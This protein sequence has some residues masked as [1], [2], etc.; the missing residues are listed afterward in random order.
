[1]KLPLAPLFLLA[2]TALSAQATPAWTFWI[3][4]NGVIQRGPAIRLK[5]APF[6]FHFK[7]LPENDFGVAATVKAEELPDFDHLEAVFRVGNGLLVDQPNTKISV[8]DEG[9]VAKGWSSWNMWAWHGPEEK[10]FIS[11]FQKRTP[12]KDGS[13]TYTRRIDQ[14]CVDDGTKDA[15]TPVATSE[16]TKVYLIITRIPF[17]KE[18]GLKATRWLEPV[19]VTLTFE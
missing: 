6:T 7:G 18:G 19:R 3:E 16:F 15:C 12:N 17:V 13:I 4:Q 11:G 1:M 2:C 8:S 14:L 9:I 10:E 5:R